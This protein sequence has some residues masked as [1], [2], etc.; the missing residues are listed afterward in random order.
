MK[1]NLFF[2]TKIFL[3]LLLLSCSASQTEEDAQ[4][5]STL[6]AAMIGVQGV[7]NDEE[8]DV[9]NDI[10][11]DE[12]QDFDEQQNINEQQE[13]EVNLAENNEQNV[14]NEGPDEFD[15]IVGQDNADAF[16][17]EQEVIA[18]QSLDQQEEGFG[19]Q[20][21]QKNEQMMFDE[22]NQ[23]QGAPTDEQTM[24]E[25]GDGASTAGEIKGDGTLVSE[26]SAEDTMGIVHWIGYVYKA[27][28]SLVNVEIVTKNNPK[29]D[30]YQEL[31]QAKQK[32]VVVRYYDTK[33]RK[34]MRRDIDASEFRSPVAYIRTR[35]GDEDGVVEVVLTVRDEVEAKYLAK[36]GS[37]LLSFPIPKRYFG[38]DKVAVGPSEQAVDLSTPLM[39][40]QM[41]DSEAPR[42]GK[43][44]GYVFNREV[45][46]N[47]GTM[48]VT[49]ICETAVPPALTGTR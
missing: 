9:E 10:Q 2:Y 19:D 35:D 13:E 34:K 8:V 5:Q 49:N 28:E 21:D 18:Q 24:V 12:Q 7:N 36:D 27:E 31:N 43:V 45:F 29:F 33:L 15:E 39:V 6:N 22:G 46:K 16:S 48:D 23:L 26:D 40:V 37:L 4:L 38:N 11:T 3:I 47:V 32:E 42:M 14:N 17:V 1:I 44:L 20:F 25:V 41:E 30:V